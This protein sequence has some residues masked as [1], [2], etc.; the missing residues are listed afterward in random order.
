MDM[1][2]PV[3]GGIEAA[4]IYNFSSRKQD[5]V[6]IVI[7]TANA[8][9]EAIQECADAKIDAY[10]TK[11]IDIKKLLSTIKNLARDSMINDTP[12]ILDNNSNTEQDTDETYL[13]FPTLD[14]LR[15]LSNEP[16][17]LKDLISGF[18]HDTEYQLTLMEHSIASCD[19]DSFKEYAHALKGSS[20]SVGASLLHK[21]CKRLHNLG[22]DVSGY[23]HAIK[24]ISNC[25]KITKKEMLKYLDETNKANETA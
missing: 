3:M 10:L 23:I 21:E 15:E 1:Q 16:S 24:S 9:K 17:F 11:P 4:K 14:A 19:L 8:T 12:T 6:P 2:M 18:L 7:L 20:G 22:K 5:R 13:D 25:Y